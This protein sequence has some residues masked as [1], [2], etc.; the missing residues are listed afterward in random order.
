MEK[1]LNELIEEYRK[2][3]NDQILLIIEK[4]QPII[5]KYVR[6]LYKDEREDTISEL[7]LSL[8]E[9]VNKIE[10]YNNEGQ[11]FKF[12]YNALRNKYLELYRKSRKRFDNEQQFYKEYY[13]Y[14]IVC[15]EYD[16]TELIED[17][18]K[19]LLEYSDKQKKILISILI[20]GKSNTEVATENNVSRQYTNRIKNKLC[21]KIK[22]E[23]TS[24]F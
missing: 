24:Y 21:K 3:D 18:N 14:C 23:Y 15:Y 1:T 12:L 20:E 5:Y 6:L 9:A 8:L 16:D 2:G 4:F 19:Y 22:K 7:N 17:L 10:Y 13:N 11:C